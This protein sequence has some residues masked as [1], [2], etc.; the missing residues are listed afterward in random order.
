M[1]KEEEESTSSEKEKGEISTVEVVSEDEQPFDIDKGEDMNKSKDGKEVSG[2]TVVSSKERLVSFVVCSDVRSVNSNKNPFTVL[3]EL[4]NDSALSVEAFPPLKADVRRV[5]RHTDQAVVVR[6]DDAKIFEICFVYSSNKENDRK[7]L[8]R[9]LV[10]SSLPLMI[11]G[12][13]NAIRSSAEA[14]N[15]SNGGSSSREF[16]DW[17]NSNNF[18]NHRVC[19]EWFTW[20]NNQDGKP[21]SR[22]LDRVLVNQEWMLKFDKSR[23]T[24]TLPHLS[25]HCGI[26]TE[27]DTSI[28]RVPS[29]FKFF[30]H[31][32][33]HPYYEKLIKD[34][35]RD[36]RKDHYM[37]DLYSNMKRDA[38]AKWD[39]IKSMEEMFYKQKARNTSITEGDS[40][41]KYFYN[42]VK[43][44]NAR[45]QIALLVSEGGESL[46]EISDISKEAVNF[47][48]KLLG[49]E[50]NA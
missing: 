7:Q 46:R 48:Q 37:E 25:D 14:S 29:A 30:N 17:I 11:N 24:T 6:V 28:G 20:L 12:D 16:N 42:K 34:N 13:F 32:T 41:T 21:I 47:Y 45:K 2:K 35:W 8:Y 26:M 1:E 44:Q 19:G 23:V 5:I 43:Y 4:E 39:N 38:T 50:D 31:W 10:N 3:Y 18:A 36:G 22:R 27:T 33:K 40:N 49:K 9:D 15:G